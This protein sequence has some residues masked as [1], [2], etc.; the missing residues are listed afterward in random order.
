MRYVQALHF[1]FMQPLTQRKVSPK[2]IGDRVQRIGEL[3]FSVLET[4]E[5]VTSVAWILLQAFPKLYLP[6]GRQ[7]YLINGFKCSMRL[8]VKNTSILL[9]RFQNHCNRVIRICIMMPFGKA[10]KRDK[11]HYNVFP[12]GVITPF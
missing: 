10:K 6:H 5:N 1:H 11:K 9:G 12:K 2:R 7:R 8:V 3:I 4:E